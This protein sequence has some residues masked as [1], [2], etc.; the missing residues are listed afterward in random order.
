MTVEGGVRLVAGSVVLLTSGMAHPQC[1]IY[2]TD[3]LL[4]LTGFV[5]FMLVQSVFT[6]ICPAAM[7]LRKLGLRDAPARGG[8]AAPS[9]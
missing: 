4:Y 5:G 9:P 8:A 3:K 6:G 1:P 2:V 7:V